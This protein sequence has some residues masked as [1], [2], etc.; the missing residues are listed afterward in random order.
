LPRAFLGFDHIDC[1]VRSIAAVEPFYDVFLSALGLER[2]SYAHVDAGGEWH[3]PGEDK[4]PNAVEY[5]E[6]AHPDRPS[7]FIGFIERPD[8]VHPLTR[9][10]FRIEPSRV[11]ELRDVLRRAGARAVETSEDF[12][13][14]PAIFFEDPGG[15]KLEIVAR[16]PG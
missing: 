3:K 2:K 10:A 7:S 11:D 12:D 4:P 8:H 16:R 9:I 13:A 5:Y 15:T 6:A 14:Y 1:R